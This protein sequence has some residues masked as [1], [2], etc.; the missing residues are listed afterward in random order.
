MTQLTDFLRSSP[1]VLAGTRFSEPDIE[2]YLV[3]RNKVNV[4]DRWGPSLWIEANPTPVTRTR[5]DRHGLLLVKGTLRDFLDWMIT[6][7]GDMPA[8]WEQYALDL[9]GV[10]QGTPLAPNVRRFG[11]SFRLVRSYKAPTKKKDR[12]S[13]FYFGEEPTW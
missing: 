2:H 7:Y 5:C 12:A 9:R 6:E 8:P 11:S 10:L 1:F 13:K 4:S 3:G